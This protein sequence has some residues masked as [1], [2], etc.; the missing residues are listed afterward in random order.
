MGSVLV[1]NIFIVQKRKTRSNGGERMSRNKS[2]NKGKAAP[3]VNPQ[4]YGQ[5]F[6]EEPKSKLEN[7]AKKSNTKR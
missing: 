4:G 3:G 7:N 5:E 1:C 2:A 6:S